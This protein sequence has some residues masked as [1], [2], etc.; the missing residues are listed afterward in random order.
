MI[1]FRH[2][3]TTDAYE[4]RLWS[5][6]KSWI[7][8]LA[9]FVLRGVLGVGKKREQVFREFI[10]QKLKKSVRVNSKDDIP[11]S[12]YDIL[13]CGSDQIWNYGATGE[14]DP[15]YF[16]DV[17]TTK[18]KFSYAASAGSFKFP[19]LEHD[20]YS[21][22]LGNLRFI[23]VRE[24]FLHD[25][26]KEEFNLD[27]V[28]NPD[29]TL[30]VKADEWAKIEMEYPRLPEQYLLVYSLHKP[31]RDIVFCPSKLEIN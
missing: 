3:H 22:L 23:G 26:L 28:V 30:F 18:C 29:P 12:K 27:S 15:M 10:D 31:R 20:K 8:N 21:R 16:L 7:R 6:Y 25:Y 19:K 5:P 9:L 2:P 11:D 17:G 24:K 13:V 1:D 4:W 14:N